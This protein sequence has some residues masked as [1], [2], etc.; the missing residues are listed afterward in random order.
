MLRALNFEHKLF[1]SNWSKD[2]IKKNKTSSTYIGRNWLGLCK[3]KEREEKKKKRKKGLHTL[4]NKR[5]LVMDVLRWKIEEE[6]LFIFGK[7]GYDRKKQF[8]LNGVTLLL[9]WLCLI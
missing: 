6:L 5:V 4:V 8:G 1:K 2:G 3:K 9:N 7:M